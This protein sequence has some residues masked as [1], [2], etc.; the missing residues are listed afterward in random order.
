MG[1]DLDFNNYERKEKAKNLSIKFKVGFGED[2]QAVQ[3]KDD[4]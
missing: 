3:E 2:D 1:Q 4:R